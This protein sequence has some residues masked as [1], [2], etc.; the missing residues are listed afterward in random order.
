MAVVKVYSIEEDDML[1]L[2]VIAESKKAYDD[3]WLYL[4]DNLKD[5][6]NL[7][8]AVGENFS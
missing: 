5:K 8:L 3:A 4:K 2:N 7:V 6:F 1:L